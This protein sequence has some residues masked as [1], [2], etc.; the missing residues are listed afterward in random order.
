M[1]TT[2]IPHS[3]EQATLFFEHYVAQHEADLKGKQVVDLSAG[4][5]YIINLFEQKGA[6]VHPFDL[7]PEQNKF[8]QTTCCFIDLQQRLPIEANWAD[9]VILSETIEHLPNQ[10]FLFEEVSRIIKPGGVFLLST[11]N[12]SSLRSRFSQFI[13]ESEHYRSPLP[14]EYN[15]LTRWEGQTSGYYAKVFI[16]GILRLRVLA[17]LNKL[18]ISKVYQTKP[19]ST[20]VWLMVFYPVIWWFSKQQLKKGIRETPQAADALR[21]IFKLNTS[22]KVLLS[23]HLI[24]EFKKEE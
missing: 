23:K 12:T 3:R 14:N 5:G 2:H 18:C 7:F 8:C 20:S 17:A 9:V 4:S 1:D 24:M 21:E 16:S 11:P 15:A 6:V 19:S 13:A 10:L 22:K